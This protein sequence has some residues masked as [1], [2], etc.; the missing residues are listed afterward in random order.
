MFL[1][2]IV[3]VP[4]TY[5]P[6]LLDSRAR[7]LSEMT[8]KIYVPKGTKKHMR[9]SLPTALR[10]ALTRPWNLLFRE[11]IV[12]LLSTY[13]AIL[14]GTVCTKISDNTPIQFSNCEVSCTCSSPAS[15][16][17][18][19]RHEVGAKASVAWLFLASV[20]VLLQE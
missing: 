12:L 16:S 9:K 13:M 4:E 3:I 1:V 6:V 8:G 7:R 19:K 11:P 17:Y 10:I 15:L 20:P 5:A 14:Y 18:T 2:V